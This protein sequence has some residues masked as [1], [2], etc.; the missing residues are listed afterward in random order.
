V[1]VNF[2]IDESIILDISF[3]VQLKKFRSLK[4]DVEE[5]LVNNF[6]PVQPL[7]D[8]TVLYR[9]FTESLDLGPSLGPHYWM[10]SSEVN[11]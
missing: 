11:V 1:L 3:L 8:R 2:G 7:N 9:S 5:P 4:N 10:Q 6:R